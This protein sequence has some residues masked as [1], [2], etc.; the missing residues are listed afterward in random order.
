MT[1]F[2]QSWWLDAV[3]PNQWNEVTAEKK[4]RIVGRMPYV[5]KRKLGFTFLIMPP[6]TQTLGP[7]IEPKDAKYAKKLAWEKEILSD[8]I[9]KLPSH[10][11]FFQN[12]SYEMTNW[13]PFYW[14]GFKQTTRYTYVLE[15]ISDPEKIWDGFLAN[16]R[17]DIR[18]ASKK[19]TVRTDLGVEKFLDINEMTFQRQ[20]IKPPYSREVVR[21]IDAACG[22]EHRKIFFAED[23]DGDIH[24]A[25]YIIWDE[26]SA[27]YLMGGGDPELRNSGAT[28]FLIWNAINFAASVTKRFDFEGSMIES[29][30]RFFRAFGATQKTYFS[31]FKIPEWMSAIF[32]GAKSILQ[33]SLE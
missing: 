26:N 18:K 32:K 14:K 9:E 20:G 8:L 23:S 19:I 16:I 29:V 4:G 33:N 17:T 2:Q 6:L 24:A 7:W 22:N 5:I 13:L 28:S 11:F 21:R 10:S 31:V 25:I 12:C 15:D 3:A 30:E 27:Y 1:I